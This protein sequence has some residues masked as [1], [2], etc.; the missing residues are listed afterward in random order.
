MASSVGSL[1]KATLVIGTG[2][3]VFSYLNPDHSVLPNQASSQEDEP[4]VIEVESEE[5]IYY[6][7]S[8]PSIDPVD[9]YKMEADFEASYQAPP[10]CDANPQDTQ[11]VEHKARVKS[12][13]EDQW[14]RHQG[15]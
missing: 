1:L 5:P 9:R 2:V 14:L 11:C 8:S 4:T 13:F 6:E 7:E 15:N 3:L 10:G 12:A